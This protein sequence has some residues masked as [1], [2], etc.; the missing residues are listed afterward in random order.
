MTKLELLAKRVSEIGEEIKELKSQRESNLQHCHGSDDEEFQFY[1]DREFN[2]ENHDLV[3][4]LMA[5]YEY[6][7]EGRLHGQYECFDEI[8]RMYGCKNCIA[9]HEAKRAIGALKQ[10]R[11]R[12]IGNISKIGKALINHQ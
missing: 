7:K 5:S 12:I 10:E 1:W 8:I 6:V 2:N 4:C 9:A 3:N 11:G